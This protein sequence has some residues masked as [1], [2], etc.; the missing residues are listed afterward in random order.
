MHAFTW[1]VHCNLN[2]ATV[3]SGRVMA[4]CMYT[5]AATVEERAQA[6]GLGAPTR[7]L[8]VGE[9]KT[10]DNRSRSRYC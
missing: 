6:R 9:G 7:P 10:V 5:R 1:R 2:R 3:R 4:T 8:W